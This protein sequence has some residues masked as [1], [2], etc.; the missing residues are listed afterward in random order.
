MDCLF[1]EEAQLTHT[2]DAYTSPA[3]AADM[4]QPAKSSVGTFIA[5]LN[6]PLRDH[7]IAE[8]PSSRGAAPQ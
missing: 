1:P 4:P 2:V 7:I 3:T 8:A 6:K 5:A